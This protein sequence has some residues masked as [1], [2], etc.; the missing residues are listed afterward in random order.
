[1]SILLQASGDAGTSALFLLA[2]TIVFI[3][4]MILP[5]RKQRREQ[6]AFL[7]ALE[8]GKNVVTSSG[9][10]GRINK[11]EDHI[12]TL[13]VDTKTHLKVAKN[14]IS[15]ELTDAIYETKSK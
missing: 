7:E 2:I 8:K 10:L 9:I 5:Q 1:M 4:T 6:K 12:V 3:F 14:A 15:K 13:E 11:I